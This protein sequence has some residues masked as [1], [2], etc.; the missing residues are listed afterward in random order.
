MDVLK[1][2]VAEIFNPILYEFFKH[3]HFKQ[4]CDKTNFLIINFQD[5]YYYFTEVLSFLLNPSCY[6]HG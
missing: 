5:F 3:P 4:L 6:F 1:Y 2:Y